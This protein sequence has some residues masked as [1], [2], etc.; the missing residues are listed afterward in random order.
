MGKKRVDVA[1]EQD[2]EQMDVSFLTTEALQ[3]QTEDLA[4]Q[5]GITPDEVVRLALKLGLARFCRTL[6]L[7]P[8][9]EKLT[10]QVRQSLPPRDTVEGLPPV[11]VELD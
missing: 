5:M 8:V 11:R 9:S 4:A 6:G 7:G 3:R 1:E 10:E 2:D